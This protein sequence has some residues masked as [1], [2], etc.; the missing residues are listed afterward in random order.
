MKFRDE[1]FSR[2][3]RYSLGLEEESGRYFSS[4]PVS[5]GVVDY[6]E[7]Y[8]LT[9]EQYATFLANP[10]EALAFVDE[11]R[12]HEHD[13]LLLQQPGRNRGTPI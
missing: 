13:D 9:G 10:T 3:Q 7:Y 4:F 6:A 8:E 2:E 11:C 1:Y 5:N 12:A